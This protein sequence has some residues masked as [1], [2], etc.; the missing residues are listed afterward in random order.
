M[1]RLY[2]EGHRELQRSSTPGGSPIGSS[3]CLHTRSTPEDRDSS[4][5]ATC[6]SSRPPTP[7]AGRTARTRAAIRFRA[8]ARRAARW[9]FPLRR[10]RHVPVVRQRAHESARRPAV[11]RLR[12]GKRLRVNGAASIEPDDPRSSLRIRARSSSSACACA[13]VSELPA[14]HPQVLSWWSARS[15]C[16]ARTFPTPVPAWK[17]YEWAKDVLPEN[18]P[19]KD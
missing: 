19:A 2:Q 8:R 17:R 12:G 1:S 18:D 16:R 9:C 11:H 10:Q 4:S 15:S 13:S 6:S 14:L 3:R 5:V 7:R